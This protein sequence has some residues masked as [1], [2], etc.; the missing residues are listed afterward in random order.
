VTCAISWGRCSL[1]R[2]L[3]VMSVVVVLVLLSISFPVED[4]LVFVSCTCKLPSTLFLSFLLHTGES[5][6]KADS[7]SSRKRKLSTLDAS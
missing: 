4:P 2:L 3:V 6:G 1:I 5:L 7:R